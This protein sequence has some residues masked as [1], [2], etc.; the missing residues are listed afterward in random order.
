MRK[1][2][3][4]MIYA[5]GDDET[6]AIESAVKMLNQGATFDEVDFQREMPQELLGDAS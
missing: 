3:K 4:L 1:E 5:I 2:F 6:D